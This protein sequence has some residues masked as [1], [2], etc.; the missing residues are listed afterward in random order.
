MFNC[1]VLSLYKDTVYTVYVSTVRD[2]I[3]RH[4]YS[5]DLDMYVCTPFC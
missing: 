3:L 4:A 1:M 5:T 2:V